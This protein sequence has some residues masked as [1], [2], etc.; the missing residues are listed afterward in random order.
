MMVRFYLLI[1]WCSLVFQSVLL[2]QMPPEQLNDTVNGATDGVNGVTP[3][4]GAG[5]WMWTVILLIIVAF[6]VWWAVR[7]GGSANR[8]GG[9]SSR[10]R[11]VGPGGRGST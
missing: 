1:A 8:P 9:P 6:I 4:Y 10:S 7:A 11:S 2:A 3:G 5:W